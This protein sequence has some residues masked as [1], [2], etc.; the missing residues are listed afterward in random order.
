MLYLPGSHA[1]LNLFKL[2]HGDARAHVLAIGR[3]L[4][5]VRSLYCGGKIEPVIRLYIVARHALAQR[6]QHSQSSLGACIA[7]IGCLA[8]PCRSLRHVAREELAAPVAIEICKM[9]F[10][11]NVSLVRG[12][13][14]PCGRLLII[15]ARRTALARLN[16]G[17]GVA[18]VSLCQQGRIN[19]R[20]RTGRLSQSGKCNPR[21][22]ICCDPSQ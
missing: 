7:L 6:V 12:L 16:L 21:Q 10:A 2:N 22:D 13:G 17:R 14:I 9:D 3:V 4:F 15:A 11:G 5:P 19:R 18:R 20:R 1:P 8:I